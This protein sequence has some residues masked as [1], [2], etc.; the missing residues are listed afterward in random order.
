MVVSGTVIMCR[1]K[2]STMR[3]VSITC[4][5]ARVDFYGNGI[6]THMPGQHLFIKRKGLT[7]PQKP[8]LFV[9]G[10]CS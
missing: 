8:C 10:M 4:A 5:L 6:G 9:N 2:A 3:V 1:W 7:R